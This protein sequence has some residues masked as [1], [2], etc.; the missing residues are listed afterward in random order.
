[1]DQ[2]L[3]SGGGEL[4]R[5]GLNALVAQGENRFRAE[6]AAVLRGMGLNTYLAGYGNEAVEI[7][8]CLDIHALVMDTQLPDFGG[9]E[10]VRVVKTFRTVP[11][12]VLL[13]DEVTSQLR[14]AALESEAVSIMRNPVDTAVLSEILQAALSRC[15]GRGRPT[16][17][18]LSRPRNRL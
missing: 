9:L 14:A 18:G 6:L 2:Q 16:W 11:P 5:I 12:F 10:I 15:Y 13:A 17:P 3:G 8:S 7:L 1:M 4:G